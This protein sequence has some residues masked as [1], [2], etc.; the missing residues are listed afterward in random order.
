[1]QS[2]LQRGMIKIALTVRLVTA[3]KNFIEY[4]NLYIATRYFL[5]LL[6]KEMK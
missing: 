3:E 5:N 6:M 4:R 2:T 1:M